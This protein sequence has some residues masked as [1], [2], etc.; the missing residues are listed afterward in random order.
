MAKN[1]LCNC[2]RCGEF[3]SNP[4]CRYTTDSEFALL[5]EHDSWIEMRGVKWELTSEEFW[6]FFKEGK[7]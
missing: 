2:K 6:E 4:L 7:R 3:C 1:Y 5:P